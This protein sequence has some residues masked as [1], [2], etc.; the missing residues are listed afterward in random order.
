MLLENDTSDQL[1]GKHP[2]K[3]LGISVK[4]ETTIF[5]L[6]TVFYLPFL[7]IAA[8]IFYN[9]QIVL[10]LRSPDYFDIGEDQLGHA[11]SLILMTAVVFSILF[12][13]CYGYIFELLG[14]K[15]PI[16]LGSVGCSLLIS[17][18]PMTAP[19]L[20]ALIVVRVLLT[21]L[22]GF[23]VNSPLIA[24]YVKNESRA[25]AAALQCA[26][27]MSGLVF[28]ILVFNGGT[29]KMDMDDQFATVSAAMIVLSL[30]NLCLIRDPVIKLKRQKHLQASQESVIDPDLDEM[31]T[32]AKVKYLTSEVK[33]TLVN[34]IRYLLSFA[35]WS[36]TML[37]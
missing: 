8:G 22:N 29:V 7:D 24:D 30:F 23:L 26:G 3:I 18:L 5:N 14:R 13:P 4:K 33:A 15:G 25:T 12:Q 1:I 35:A 34:D 20:P 19:S 16:I 28:G 21:G 37:I 2:K 11:T 31:T 27:T 6:F 17:V 32:C 36:S 10:L 9:S